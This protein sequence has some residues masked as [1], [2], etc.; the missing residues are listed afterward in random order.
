MEKERFAIKEI[1]GSHEKKIHLKKYSTKA[2]KLF[3]RFLYG[4]EL[5]QNVFWSSGYLIHTKSL[6]S[7]KDLT[8]MGGVYNMPSLQRAAV[9][10]LVGYVDIPCSLL[11]LAINT[12]KG[13]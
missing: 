2:V 9:E 5:E 12:R 11:L 10:A 1:K 7:V 4:F 8:V 6:Q 13:R 3:I